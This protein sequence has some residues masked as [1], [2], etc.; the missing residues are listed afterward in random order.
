MA[1]KIETTASA[2]LPVISA[3][4]ELEAAIRAARLADPV[5]DGPDGRRYVFV[6][7]DFNLSQLPDDTRL[8][9]I[10][11]QRVIVD[12][13]ASLVTYANRFR[14]D[15]SIIV[16]DFDALEIAA[17]LDWHPHNAMP[18]SFGQSGALKHSVTLKLRASE[19]FQRWDAMEG[20]VHPQ[21]EFARF[22]EENS[23]DVGYPEAATM[24]EISRD[25]EATVGQS[26]KS[27]VRL[28]N[29][30][31]KLRFESETKVMNDVIIPERFTLNIPI[32]NGEE[33]DTLTALFRWRAV[34]G[35]AVAL[36]FQW[37]RV[38]YQRRAHFAQIASTAAEETG[39]PWIMGRK[40]T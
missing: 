12:D 14:D 16:A 10:P 18:D 5:I 30:D 21:E 23:S 19:E 1:Q 33:P 15:R 29:G 32:Y 27:S 13:R 8:P 34:G 37:H 31:R 40:A 6:P 24:V 35:G 36:G 2:P 39:L 20:K 17:H 26:Y 38:E 4:E 11:A 3:G 9:A 28:D 22:L 7:R 25:F